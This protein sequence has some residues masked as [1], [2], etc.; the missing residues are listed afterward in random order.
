MNDDSKKVAK[1]TIEPGCIAC[2]SCAFI[3][4]QVFAVTDRSRVKES[5][6]FE[7]QSALIEK[8]AAA[9][10]VSVINYKK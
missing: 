7:S 3:A 8:A 1:P 4:P 5:A 10:P 6:D 9:C 2:G